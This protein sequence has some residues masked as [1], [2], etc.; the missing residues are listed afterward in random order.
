MRREKATT[1][2]TPFLKGEFRQQGF[3][4]IGALLAILIILAVGVLVFTVTT[5]D[6]RTSTRIVGEKKA[7]AAAEA[8][9]HYAI[10]NFSA[11]ASVTN[12]VVDAATDPDSRFSYT[13]SSTGR[14]VQ[15]PGYDLEKWNE[16]L[17]SMTVTGEN[18]KYGSKVQ[19]DTGLSEFHSGT[20]SKT[21]E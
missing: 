16:S 8:G 11:G 13:L 7:F 19:I 5:Q 18:T 3:A 1:P 12:Q 10:Q 4:L 17:Y 20:E 21:T 14:P 6:I 2:C 15:P 9:V